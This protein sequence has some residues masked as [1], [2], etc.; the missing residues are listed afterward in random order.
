LKSGNQ[1]ARLNERKWSLRGKT[2]DDR[3]FDYFRFF[4][5]GIVSLL[6]LKEN[7]RILDLG[8]GSGWA[9][10]YA[11]ALVNQ[12]GEFY[13]I[14][15]S[16]KMIEKARAISS[17]YERMH[18]S[19]ANAEQLPFEDGFFDFI[20]C[21]NS[22]RHYFSPS[23]VLGEVSR[24]LRSKG[25]IYILDPTADGFI[26]KRVDKWLKDKEPEHVQFYGSQEYQTLFAGAGLNYVASKSMTFPVIPVRVLF[27]RVHI[28]EKP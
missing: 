25:R 6:D 10:R 26:M 23:K 5:R 7:Q 27:I 20:I 3:R 14:D 21:S 28:G 19:Q 1:H 16:S 13:G 18:F 22:F 4:Q 15:I 2:Y 11:A 12:R 24:V 8:C 17:G 9:L